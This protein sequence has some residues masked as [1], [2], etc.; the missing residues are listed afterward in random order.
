MLEAAGGTNDGGR[1][2]GGTASTGR[3][4]GAQ[5]LSTS[6]GSGVLSATV[7]TVDS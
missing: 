6:G 4:R 1:S 2:G 3:Q 7:P 5:Y